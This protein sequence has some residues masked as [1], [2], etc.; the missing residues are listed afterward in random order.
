MGNIRKE[1]IHG[2]S[3][4]SLYVKDV[5]C[6]QTSGEGHTAGRRAGSYSDIV[7]NKMTWMDSLYL[8]ELHFNDLNNFSISYQVNINY[9]NIQRRKIDVKYGKTKDEKND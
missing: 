8:Q 5:T 6:V 9:F 2:T 3:L 7:K 4:Q 1:M